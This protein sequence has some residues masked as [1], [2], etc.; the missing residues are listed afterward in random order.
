MTLQPVDLSRPTN[1]RFVLRF[2]DVD[3]WRREVPH[4]AVLGIPESTLICY[5]MADQIGEFNRE[6]SKRFTNA[7]DKF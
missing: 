7:E 2:T 1:F 5:D 3:T 6:V 4:R